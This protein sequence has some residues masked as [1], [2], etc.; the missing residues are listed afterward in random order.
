M[1]RARDIAN[2][3]D[4][5]ATADIDDGAVTAAKINS[6]VGLGKVLQVVQDLTTTDTTISDTGYKDT[7]LTGTIT[8]SSTSSKIL[9]MIS[10]SIFFDIDSSLGYGQMKLFR[11]TTEL[12]EYRYMGFIEVSSAT[13][14]KNGIYMPIHYLDSPTTTDAITYK[15][16]GRPNTFNNNGRVRFQTG[17]D[18]APSYITLLEIEG[19]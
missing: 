6:A 10:Q 13:T 19:S 2:F 16:Q 17:G 11:G 8:P 4:G 1:T 9:I 14:V 7:T 12:E 3:G 18:V 15:T 5:I